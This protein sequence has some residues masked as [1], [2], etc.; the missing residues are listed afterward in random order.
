MKGEKQEGNT[1]VQTEEVDA[2]S[3]KGGKHFGANVEFIFRLRR[4]MAKYEGTA[5]D[6]C[7]V[8]TK[9]SMGSFATGRK[10]TL[11]ADRETNLVEIL[12]KLGKA[13]NGKAL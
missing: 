2:G 11:L 4:E 1:S 8:D 3:C 10:A 9:P 7:F 12:K 13:T 6:K 5:V